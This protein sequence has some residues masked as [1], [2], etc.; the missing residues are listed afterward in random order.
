MKM[1]Y[2]YASA[3]GFLP[4][5]RV[6]F[7]AF[8]HALSL[9]I[10]VLMILGNFAIPAH[11]TP[12]AATMLY[13]PTSTPTTTYTRKQ[14]ILFN[15]TDGSHSINDALV[16]FSTQG[17]ASFDAN[18][19]YSK[20]ASSFPLLFLGL[21]AASNATITFKTD[22]PLSNQT[23]YC[24]VKV[25]CNNTVARGPSVSYISTFTVTS[26][27]WT[28]STINAGSTLVKAAHFTE[29]RTAINNVRQVWGYSTFTWADSSLTT[30][31]SLIRVRHIEDLRIALSQPYNRATGSNPTFTDT[32]ISTGT[33]LI[34]KIHI[35]EL[36]RTTT[37]FF[38][39][40]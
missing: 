12:S 16:E 10:S 24:R 28:D 21:P 14:R 34:R 27:T 31:S 38:P 17:G 4:G 35:D 9:I 8:G 7:R 36:R 19:F 29:L 13:P 40:P 11:A 33:T 32:L 15:G 37:G 39:L 1:R 5:C 18:V 25:W 6:L 22:T 2:R 30:G 23:L 3:A 26:P 20:Q